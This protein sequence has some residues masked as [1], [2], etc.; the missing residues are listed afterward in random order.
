MFLR[1]NHIIKSTGLFWLT[2]LEVSIRSIASQLLALSE[3]ISGRNAWPNRT[4]HL[5]SR[6]KRRKERSE[7]PLSPRLV[8][9]TKILECLSRPY[10]LGIRQYHNGLVLRSKPLICVNLQTPL[11]HLCWGFRVQ[12]CVWRHSGVVT[13]DNDQR[14]AGKA[15]LCY[16]TK[17]GL[18][19][20]RLSW[21]KDVDGS[22]SSVLVPHSLCSWQNLLL[23]AQLI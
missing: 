13:G 15:I 11:K 22:C 3:I 17:S 7:I 10:L 23:W 8:H 9:A 21:L 14:W 4:S 18:D 16:A 1:G 5:M 19:L 12:R 2:V 20:Q 6:K